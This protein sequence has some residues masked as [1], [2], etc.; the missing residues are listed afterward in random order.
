MRYVVFGAGAI[1]G[2]VGA[3]LAQH[4]HDVA[5]VAR[6]EHGEQVA[7][8]G[9]RVVDADGTSVLRLDVGPTPEAVGVG[10]DDVVLLA[11]KSQ[12]TVAALDALRDQAPDVVVAC[13]QNGVANE[14]E[15]LRRFARVQA[16]NVMLPAGHL[17]PGEVA[18]F[19]SPVTGLLDVGRYP[20]GTDA[21]TETLV[22]AFDRSGFDARA[23]GE[24]MR[25]K[26]A[27]LLMNLGNVL[28]ALVGANADIAP[29]YRTLVDEAR[30]CF[31]A[32]G[33]D[34]ASREED[35]NRRGDLMTITDVPGV[36][37]QGGSSW[38]SMARGARSIET[39][40]L[41][42]EV[43]LLGRVHGV[44]APANALVQ[45]LA[46]DAVAHGRAPGWI[47]AAELMER[48]EATSGDQSLTTS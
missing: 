40:F 1:G 33:I 9:L 48:I 30:A 21:V 37:R 11:V 32:A 31:A 19:S 15:A 44:P 12:D 39:D 17:G 43:V 45:S 46:A 47:S 35:R 27:K 8:A 20:S 41:N 22:E 23:V 18:A 25:W 14:R 3:R 26:H 6:G 29:A 2:V 42:G 24:V 36:P 4:G 38:Q 10:G 28:Q 16:V 34:A 7:A 13:L 5:L